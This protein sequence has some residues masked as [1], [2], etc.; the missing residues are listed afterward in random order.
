MDPFG[1]PPTAERTRRLGVEFG[2]VA[3]GDTHIGKRAVGLPAG[4]NNKGV[5][6]DAAPH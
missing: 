5:E 4:A 3:G 1:F 2:G 6:G